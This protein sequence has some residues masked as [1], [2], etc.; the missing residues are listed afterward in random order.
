LHRLESWTGEQ[1]FLYLFLHLNFLPKKSD[2]SVHLQ[3]HLKFQLADL[4][5]AT[6]YVIVILVNS[7][8]TKIR[9]TGLICVIFSCWFFYPV[10]VAFGFPSLVEIPHLSCFQF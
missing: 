9:F 1:V 10:L 8:A 7:A 5:Q 2:W 3:F 6:C 4:I